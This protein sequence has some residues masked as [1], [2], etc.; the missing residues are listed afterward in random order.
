LAEAMA[1]Q[2]RRHPDPERALHL[3]LAAH[4]PKL[5]RRLLPYT[6]PIASHDTEDQHPA[7]AVSCRGASDRG[8]CSRDRNCEPSARHD[9]KLSF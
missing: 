8:R 2:A 1:R 5:A 7:V 3:L 4:T 6:D 9:G